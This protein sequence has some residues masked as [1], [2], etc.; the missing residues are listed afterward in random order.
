MDP[1]ITATERAE[2][3]QPEQYTPGGDG[4]KCADEMLA[5]E[6]RKWQKIG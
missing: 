4:P 6:G 5:R 3:P 2:A 1:L